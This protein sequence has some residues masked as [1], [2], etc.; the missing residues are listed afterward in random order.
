MRIATV[1]MAAM[2]LAGTCLSA[3]AQEL[4]IPPQDPVA[5]PNPFA[6]RGI[7]L[8]AIVRYYQSQGVEMVS[9]GDV[10]GAK[11]YLGRGPNGMSQ[12]I[13][14]TPDG[15]HAVAGIVLRSGGINDTNRQIREMMLRFSGAAKKAGVGETIVPADDGNPPPSDLPIV[16]WFKSKG[17]IVT[18]I[19]MDEGGVDAVLLQTPGTKDH[20]QRLQALYVLPDNHY[21]VV[22]QLLRNDGMLV[23]ALQMADLESKGR[24]EDASKKKGGSDISLGVNKPA[25]EEAAFPETAAAP[26]APSPAQPAAPGVAD[27]AIPDAAPVTA[28]V[29]AATAPET[30]VPTP[31]A[32]PPSGT[33]ASGIAPAT[34]AASAYRTSTLTSQ[35]LTDALKSTAFFVVGAKD[36]P[37]LYMVA[38]PQC[39]W[40][41]EA[42]RQLQPEISSGKIQLR[43]IMIAG[44]RGSEEMVRSILSREGTKLADGTDAGDGPARAWVDGEGSVNGVRVKPGP[45]QGTDA[46][47][48]AGN[49]MDANARF[50]ERFGISRTPFLAYVDKNSDVYSTNGLPDS[51]GGF[52]TA[53]R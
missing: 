8:P 25:A 3:S 14:P 44:I 52:L 24:L 37:A 50:A 45:M 46:W 39:P 23:T 17:M 31:E 42:W 2:L 22:G 21:A 1:A 32:T 34:T 19:P 13:V 36:A 43:I 20:P 33:S 6:G 47:N 29:P 18:D 16:D 49:W 38:D 35:A 26:I 48:A 11:A 41:H 40:C 4:V 28:Q 27:I 12:T 10:G 9:L 15:K 5:A 30:V 53:I 51:M 7:G